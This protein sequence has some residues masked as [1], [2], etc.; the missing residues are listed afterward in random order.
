MQPNFIK[1]HA[2]L[3]KYFSVQPLF[4]DGNQQKKPHIRKCIEQPFQQTEAQLWDE[5]TNTL[6]SLE[7]IQAKACFRMTYELVN[8]LNTVLQV[9]PDNANNIYIQHELR[10]RIEV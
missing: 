10:R 8:D 7:F 9:I 3:A 6:C 4:F 5:V 1:Y 2:T